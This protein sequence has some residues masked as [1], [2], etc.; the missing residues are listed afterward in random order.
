MLLDPLLTE[1]ADEVVFDTL[2]YSAGPLPEQQLSSSDF[3]RDCP[4]WVDICRATGDTEGAARRHR[5]H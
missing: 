2:S 1:G 3:P 5:R 4:V